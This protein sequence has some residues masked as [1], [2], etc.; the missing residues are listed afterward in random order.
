MADE[1][2]VTGMMI[3]DREPCAQLCEPC[4]KGKQTCEKIHK[5]T[6]T[7]SEHV[8]GHIFSDMCG[9]LP[10]QS[11]RGYKYFVTFTDDKS[12]WVSIAPLK[13]KSEVGHHLKTFIT[14]AELE[15]GLKVKALRSDGGGEYTAKHVQQYLED[16]GITHEMTTADTPQHNGVAERLNRTLLDKT[17]AMLSDANLPK[18]YWLEA[19]N[20]A[21][22]LHN[23][24]LS[25]SIG[26]TPTEEYT[27]TKP[28]ISRLRVFGCMAHVHVPAH[29]RGKLSAHLMACTFLGFAQQRSAFRVVHRPTKK[30][31]ESRDVVFD[32]GGPTPRHEHIILEPD[33]TPTPTS[34]PV[35]T[36]PPPATSPPPTTSCPKHTIHPPVR[37]DDPRYDVSSY[38]HRANI[39][40]DDTPEPKTYDEAM[41]SPD[42]AEWLAAYEE[43]MR[44]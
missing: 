25:K 8:L 6:S 1:E 40:L 34:T 20:Y 2:L 36:H 10:T 4:L 35:S 43:E 16:R 5:T 24:S 17:R 13:E 7:H 15:T 39:A 23:V 11:H 26:T 44:T 42:T 32:E 18:S 19:L 29:A 28:D 30:F 27:G 41:A 14:K 38:G 33:N 31:L 22:L 37:D 21:V 3:S 12:H 9:P